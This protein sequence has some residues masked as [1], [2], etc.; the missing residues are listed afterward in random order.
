[1][2]SSTEA[3][4]ALIAVSSRCSSEFDVVGDDLRHRH[5]R[6]VHDH[7]AETEAV[8]DA[9]TFQGHG[10]PNGDRRALR[11]NALEFAR[12]DHLGKKHGGGLESLDLFLRIGAPRAVLHDQHADRRAAAQDRHAEERLIDLFA[13]LGFVRERRMMLGVG[14]RKRLGARGDKADEAL[15]GLHRR[16]VD[17]FT[18]EAFGRK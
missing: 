13:R 14:Q 17:G 15:A 18:V 2:R 7:M 8:G 1:M 9:L 12:C 4:I 3:R 10:P 11:R 16:Q 5:A 6:L